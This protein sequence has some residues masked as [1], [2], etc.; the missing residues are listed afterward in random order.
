MLVM[1]QTSF[2]NSRTIYL[3]PGFM[4]PAWMLYP[5][6]RYLQATFDDVNRWDY[7][8][9]FADVN[10]TVQTLADKLDRHVDGS[11]TLVAHSFGDWIVRAALHQMSSASVAALVSVCP[12][13]SAV[14]AARLATKLTGDMIPELQIMSDPMQAGITVP[15]HMPIQRSIIWAKAEVFVD[16]GENRPAAVRQRTVFASHNSVLLQPNVWKVIR[17]ELQALA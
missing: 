2:M 14:T 4:S 17:D 5:L 8:R 7:P 1:N 12:V 9:V 3:I 15:N 10:H 13:L 11:V 16:R 6:Q